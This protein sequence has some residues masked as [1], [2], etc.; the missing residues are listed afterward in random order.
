MTSFRKPGRNPSFVTYDSQRRVKRDIG[1][2][3]DFL[4]LISQTDSA[5]IQT[6]TLSTALNRKTVY[7][8]QASSQGSQH[9]VVEPSGSKLT[10][11]ALRDSSSS[12]DSLGR[13]SNSTLTTDPRFGERPPT[14]PLQPTEPLWREYTYALV[15]KTARLSATL[16]THLV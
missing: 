8:T 13:V 16:K 15:L 12:S 1:P 3:G 6:V 7:Q 10:Y 14:A 9:S 11:S 2:G 4:E 5:G